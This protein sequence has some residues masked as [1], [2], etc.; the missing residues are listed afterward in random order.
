M[1]LRHLRQRAPVLATNVAINLYCRQRYVIEILKDF[2]ESV[3]PAGLGREWGAQFVAALASDR[4]VWCTKRVMESGHQAQGDILQVIPR[5]SSP[6]GL[7]D[8]TGAIRLEG[9]G[10]IRFRL[11]PARR[12]KLKRIVIGTLAACG[13]ILLAAGIVHL[14]RPSNDTSAYAATNSATAPATP[15]PAV[16]PPLATAAPAPA[17]VPQTGTLTLQRPAAPG[18][19]WLDGQKISAA[20]ATV[21]C[22]KHQLKVGARSKPRAIDIPCG[23]ELKVTR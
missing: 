1:S 11:A 2:D 6:G 21:T 10:S 17:D 15:P 3:R 4:Q 7:A 16:S 12:R 22:G 9:T 8:G 13:A 5:R 23:G 18:R 14:V 19:V 20:S